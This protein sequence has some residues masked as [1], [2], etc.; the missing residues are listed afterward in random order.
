MIGRTPPLALVAIDIPIKIF[1]FVT[2]TCERLGGWT[3]GE[4]REGEPEENSRDSS[5]PIPLR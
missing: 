3:E 1:K 4:R 5:H 2:E